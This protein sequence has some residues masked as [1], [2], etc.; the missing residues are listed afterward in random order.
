MSR[1]YP[2]ALDIRGRL[3]V[4]VGGGPVA[5]RKIAGLRDAGALV[6]LVSIDAT[7]TLRELAD[8]GEIEYRAGEYAADSL[9]GAHLVF[10]ATSQRQVNARIAA[11]ARAFNLPV[12][13]SDAP[14]EGTFVLPSVVRRGD[15]CV[16]VST[17]GNNP[18][19]AAR[20]ADE[21]E[22]RFGPEY[23]VYVALLGAVRETIKEWTS[24]P[25]LRR[26]A[27][28]AIMDREQEIRARLA[29][30]RPDEAR[31]L[32]LSIARQAVDGQ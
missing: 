14:E 19:L 27:A 8:R 13:V 29:A 20:L 30:G 15:F 16:T 11:D 3:C 18:M 10:A 24:D 22:L 28:A 7:P 4:V 23:G 32:A 6:R 5:E 31:D 25:S 1:Y 26:A 9:E 12:S 2:I 17:G 21:L